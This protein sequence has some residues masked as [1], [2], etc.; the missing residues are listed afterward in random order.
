M[1]GNTFGRALRLT[2]FGESHGPGLGGVLDGCPAGI[3][4]CEADIQKELDRRKP[5]QGPTATKRKEADAVRLLSGV[6]EG[7]TTG[8]SLAFYIANEDQRSHDYGN[9]AEVFRPG[10][11]DWAYFRK[12]NGVRDYRGGGRASGRET[13][14]RVAGG[15]IARKILALRGVE[16]LGAC[17]A[18][19][20][21]AV[22]DWAALDLEGA[23]NRPYCAA[24]DAMPALWDKAVAAARKAGDTLGGIVRV[25][26]RHVPAGLGEP[27]F[28]KLEALLGHAI[29]SVGAVKGFSVGEG[30]G[31]AAL[32]GS[33][34]NDPLLPQTP[35]CPG[36]ADFAS[37]HAGGI[38]GGISSG[39]D[40]VLHAAVKPIASIA[41]RQ[42]TVD[43]QGQAAEA[44]IGGR[45]DLAAIPRIVPV[46]E[47]MTALTLADA[48]LLQ[49]RMDLTR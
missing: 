14:A 2:T 12:Y 48:L 31:A 24:T 32:R 21:V 43:K 39:Q 20:G 13:A 49:L 19:G 17:V 35:P 46:L 28:D 44:L 36:A 4:L 3:P 25:E 1:A 26:T 37:N 16:V 30:F 47:A 40:I 6:F 38:L 29:M 9:L 18:L 45:H 33:Q 11:A 27:V 10:Q 5:G 22:Q 7:V 42:R 34:N 8:T 23:R 41:I 15:V